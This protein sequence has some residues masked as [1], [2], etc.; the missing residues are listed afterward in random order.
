MWEA[1]RTVLTIQN[2]PFSW[3]VLTWSISIKERGSLGA[4]C[5]L[6]P[7]RW[8]DNPISAAHGGQIWGRTGWKKRAVNTAVR[9]K[10]D[11]ILVS[12]EELQESGLEDTIV[13]KTL[14]SFWVLLDMNKNASDAWVESVEGNERQIDCML[15]S[16]LNISDEGWSADGNTFLGEI[17]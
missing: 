15:F 14:D 7:L 16:H 1:L 3:E 10:G 9:E 8:R 13:N 17:N 5:F 2:C 6:F 4:I 11:Q 12:K